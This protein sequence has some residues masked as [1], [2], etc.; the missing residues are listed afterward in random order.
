MKPSQSEARKKFKNISGSMF[1]VILFE[2]LFMGILWHLRHESIVI[3][4]IVFFTLLTVLEVEN[5]IT[6]HKE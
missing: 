6:Q 2:S 1:L 4:V 3:T 5:Y